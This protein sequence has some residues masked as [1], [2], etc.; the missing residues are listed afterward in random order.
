MSEQRQLLADSAA[1]SFETNAGW[2]E[3]EALG[4]A[5]ILVTE[6]RGGSGADWDDTC[7]VLQAAGHWQIPL[8]LAEAMIARKLL[9]AAA[10]EVPRSQLGIAPNPVG[11]LA[12]EGRGWKFSG[13]LASVPWGRDVTRVVTTMPFDGCPHVVVLAV[14]DA[15]VDKKANLA[16]EPRDDLRFDGTSAL[17]AP[18]ECREAASLFDYAALA[19]IAQIA[20]ALRRG[21]GRDVREPIRRN[22]CRQRRCFIRNRSGEVA[23]Q[24]SHRGVDGDSASSARSY[25][26]H[27]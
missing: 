8:P 26:L 21:G 16:D 12:R 4:I 10:L 24:P 3:I 19:R 15:R 23:G 7:A 9:A 17:A 6:E 18:A 25:R 20:G 1:R 5:D 13:A 14:A 22:R 27:A 11:T 2:D